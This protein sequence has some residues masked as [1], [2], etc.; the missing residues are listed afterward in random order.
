[1]IEYRIWY[2]DGRSVIRSF[3]SHEEAQKYVHLD[4]EDIDRYWN[5]TN[6]PQEETND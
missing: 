3:P 4:G 1:M 5:V 2:T 6:Y